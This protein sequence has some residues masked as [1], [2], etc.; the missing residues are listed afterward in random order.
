MR[1]ENFASADAS[2]LSAGELNLLIQAV[3]AAALL[4]ART[5]AGA[6]PFH[7]RRSLWPTSYLPEEVIHLT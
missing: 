6:E 5:S 3:T 7:P 2:L 1:S 4:L